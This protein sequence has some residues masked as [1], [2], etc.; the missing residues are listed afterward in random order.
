MYQQRG[1]LLTY[2]P[3]GNFRVIIATESRPQGTGGGRGR[4]R[5]DDLMYQVSDNINYSVVTEKPSVVAADRKSVG[6]DEKE[7]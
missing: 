5:P 4:Q 3:W 7:G 6:K 1:G 2:T